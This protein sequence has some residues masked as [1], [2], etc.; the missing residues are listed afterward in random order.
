MFGDGYDFDKPMKKNIWLTRILTFVFAAVILTACGDDHDEDEPVNSVMEKIAG[1]WQGTVF[2]NDGD[3]EGTTI[4]VELGADGSYKDYIN[5]HLGGNGKYEYNGSQIVVPSDCAV[6]NDWGTT[7]TVT[8]S[9]S[10]MVWKN[11][12]MSSYHGAEYRFTKK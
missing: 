5:G 12:S 1:T 11:S 6:A 3:D 8:I 4:R 7:Y 2:Y 10:T 9:G